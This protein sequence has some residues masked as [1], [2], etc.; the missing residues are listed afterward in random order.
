V[1]SDDDSGRCMTVGTTCAPSQTSTTANLVKLGPGVCR[2]PGVKPSASMADCG[3]TAI[4]R[5]RRVTT[6]LISSF[7]ELYILTKITLKM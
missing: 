6:S 1:I 2:G 5:I 7:D 3:A 4:D